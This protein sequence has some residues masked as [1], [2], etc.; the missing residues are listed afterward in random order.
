VIMEAGV[1]TLVVG[2]GSAGLATAAALVKA[3]QPV[4]LLEKADQIGASWAGRYDSL[5]L[6]TVRWLSGL[7]GFRIP[8]SY[9][10]WV[11]RDDLIHYLREYAELSG[12]RPELGVTVERIERAEDSGWLVVTDRG[13]RAFRRVVLATGG[14]HTPRLPDWPGLETF[15]REVVHSA[16]YREPSAYAGRDV[17]VVGAGN[18]ATE[19]A[20]DLLSVGATVTLSVR[21]PPSILRREILG[22]P[23]QLLGLALIKAPPGVINPLVAATRRVSVP[24]LSAQG[25]PR[26]RNPYT[27]FKETGTVPIIDSGIVAAVRLGRV[28]VAAATVSFDGPR[29]GLSDGS[30]VEPDAVIAATGFTTGLVPLVGHLGVLDSRGW[31]LADGANELPSARGLYFV[32]IQPRIAGQLFEIARQARAVGEAIAAAA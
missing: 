28:R 20:L 2:A 1:G 14:S 25:L 13:V 27:Q 18:S 9:G 16:D 24:D 6:H 10:R 29:V 32:A 8:R 26:I 21:T 22:L 5:H 23:I 7:P 30:T 11:A 12:L 17:L 31:P 3:G 4:S 19:I 15:P